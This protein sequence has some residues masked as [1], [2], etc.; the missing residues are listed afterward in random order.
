MLRLAAAL[1]TLGIGGLIVITGRTAKARSRVRRASRR[2]RRRRLRGDLELAPLLR[3]TYATECHAARRAASGSAQL[4]ISWFEKNAER[5]AG[6]T[7]R[8]GGS[9]AA[10]PASPF[11]GLAASAVDVALAASARG[12]AAAAARPPL[13]VLGVGCGD[14]E[15]DLRLMLALRSALTRAR[16]GAAR[17]RY[18]ALEPNGAAAELF[19]AR[20]ELARSTGAL[21]GPEETSALILEERF[22]ERPLRGSL[23]G[24]SSA[25]S[26]GGGDG[27]GGEGGE[28]GEGGGGA[29]LFRS[30]TQFDLVVGVHVVGSSRERE[31]RPADA[32]G[33]GAAVQVARA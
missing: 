32:V 8:A 7:G 30:L 3:G 10:E 11:G 26:G 25:E 31:A 17:L 13:S 6:L 9:T 19:R 24:A 29:P 12:A 18:V 27:G 1:L 15:V 23:G 28:G 2:A 22:D 16:P 33:V 5:L 21:G 20:L 14:G 4:V